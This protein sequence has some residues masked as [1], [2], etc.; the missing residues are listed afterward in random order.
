MSIK[1]HLSSSS[2]VEVS[3]EKAARPDSMDNSPPDWAKQLIADCEIT[4]NNTNHLVMEIHEI[5]I[6]LQNLENRVDDVVHRCA[7]LESSAEARDVKLA[8]A[9]EKIRLLERAMDEQVDRGLRNTISFFNIPITKERESWDETTAVLANFLGRLPDLPGDAADW[10]PRI[11]RAHRGRSP[12]I[13]VVFES[14]RYTEMVRLQFRKKQGDVFILDKFSVGTTER[15][16]L[17]TAKRRQLRET[18]PTAKIYTKYPAT[19]MMKAAGE[20]KYIEVAKF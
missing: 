13:H 11:E 12:V 15:R 7:T 6:N 19:L 10:L 2:S 1:R 4:K 17:A 8:S 14:W 16:T 20:T 9:E 3:V 18:R 5:K